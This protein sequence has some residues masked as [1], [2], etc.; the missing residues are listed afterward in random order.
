MA[1]NHLRN[2][3][4]GLFS[5]LEDVD[6][7]D[8]PPKTPAPEKRTPVQPHSQAAAND[9]PSIK[10][11]TVST[12][13]D[14]TA[15]I[16][17]LDELLRLIVDLIKVDFDLYHV[18]IYFLDEDA[19]NL[20]PVAGSGEIGRQMK[21][22]GNTLSLK[23]ERALAARS[24]R[25]K[26]EEIDNNLYEDLDFSPDP[27]LPGVRAELAV[28]LVI[29]DRAIGA[30]DVYAA[31]PNHF[32]PQD[33]SVYTTLAAQI[34][35]AEQNTRLLRDA[36]KQAMR[37]TMLSEMGQALSATTT[38]D[39]MF[40]VAVRYT[41]QIVH[42]H[43]ADIALLT[44]T[45]DRL[46][47]FT[48]QEEA[49][50]VP[51]GMQLSL[52]G[53]AVGEAVR[54]KTL[55]NIPDL[56]KSNFSDARNLADQ[57]L[58]SIL[59]APLTTGEQVLGTLSV[60]SK[61]YEAYTPRDEQLFLHIATFLGSTIESKRLFEQTQEVLSATER[62][63]NVSQRINMSVSLDD[64]LAAVA[65]GLP[66]PGVNR[67]LLFTFEYDLAGEVEAAMI[68]AN[69]HS[70]DGTPPLPVGERYSRAMFT[71]INPFL[72]AESS[73][74]EDAQNSAK[75]E[76]SVF[77]VL[78]QQNI[79]A[80]AVLPLWVGSR[81]LGTIVLQGES[82]HQ[83]SQRE[84][85]SYLSA[86]P[87]I[88]SAVE[89]GRLLMETRAVLAE[90]EETQKR[91]TLQ[92]WEH[93]RSGS[94]QNTFG[95]EQVREGVMPMGDELPPEINRVLSQSQTIV[96]DASE[97]GDHRL[98]TTEGKPS[99]IVPLTLREEVIGVLGLQD[100]ETSHRWFP[101][102]IAMVEAIA[103]QFSQVAEE[104][105]LLDETQQRAAR[106]RRVGEIGDKIRAAQS[107]EEALQIAVKEVGLSLQ[108]PQTTVQLT[109][110]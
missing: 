60:C 24:A 66:V 91:Y 6:G 72:G 49:G 82:A 15:T 57:G 47:I 43:Q 70:G 38:L 20:F 8:Q 62:L 88:A 84:I 76:Q 68:A 100:T 106:E 64:I 108:A 74:I 89:N 7:V 97:Y 51:L 75:V 95:Y 71:A 104:L 53:T 110:D 79:R 22:R 19:E 32:N 40:K 21:E 98:A 56:L 29:L 45:G 11:Q 42:A 63:Y 101:E 5:D 85:Q 39:E 36:D 2:Q 3:L 23:D 93:Y 9:S 13:S 16:F 12:I 17:D 46:D 34:V 78:E 58:G 90:I 25:N 99:L 55:V 67:A 83:F 27:L 50:A 28:P 105:R 73:F 35:V 14:L 92:S 94:E 103:T 30:L 65:E 59:V 86:A 87:Q 107:L 10:L 44:D 80:L 52:E 48:L 61:P 54:E 33:I 26:R 77:F 37:L 69:W 81:Q 109:V 102:E 18:Q 1:D 96:I 4:S 31:Q 41:P